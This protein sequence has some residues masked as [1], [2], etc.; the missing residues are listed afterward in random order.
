MAT[1]WQE[2]MK[3]WRLD[4]NPFVPLPPEFG[5]EEKLK[6]IFTGRESEINRICGLLTPP[7]GF[8]ICG[9]YGVGKTILIQEVFR[10]LKSQDSITVYTTLDAYDGFRKTV[11]KGLSKTLASK[12]FREAELVFKTL[13]QGEYTISK[14]KKRK[15]KK[16]VDLKVVKGDIDKIVEDIETIVLKIDNPRDTIEKLIKMIRKTGKKVVIAVDD[17]ERKG[18]IA[19][20]QEII[21]D[22]RDILNFGS[23][24]ILTGH[25]IGVTK[26]LRT[27]SGG[28]L[29]E[30][31]LEQLSR[32]ELT[33]MMAKY[34]NTMRKDDNGTHPFDSGTADY[35]SEYSV[36]NKLT[37]RLFNLACFH[38]LDKAAN[39][40]LEIINKEFLSKHWSIISQKILKNIEEKD[41]QYLKIIY[42][43]GKISE[44][45]DEAI[46]QIGGKYAEI[47]EV[48]N[49]MAHLLRNDVLIER[50]EEQKKVIE[51][52]P[53]LKE[54]PNLFLD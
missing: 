6:Q 31:I 47:H 41:K 39:E 43:L 30:V 21:D 7:R 48:R 17:L 35:I 12:G 4:G 29:C 44:D 22:S 25:P 49:S 34:L 14:G 9:M 27:S 3:K 33:I 23:S 24:L 45:S 40:G 1:K 36:K 53:F 20:M 5:D 8:F 13:T 16:G 50:E 37:P 32:E 38:L 46:I 28:I 11:L 10:Q 52:N 26:D 18:D 19:S 54:N 15:S 51:V 2:T 42:K